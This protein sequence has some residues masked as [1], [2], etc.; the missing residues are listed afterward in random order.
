ME[1]VEMGRPDGTC[2]S[3]AE[4]G[5]LRKTQTGEEKGRYL[6][7]AFLQAEDESRGKGGSWRKELEA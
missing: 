2:S 3:G 1:H 4:G 7:G 6:G 5:L